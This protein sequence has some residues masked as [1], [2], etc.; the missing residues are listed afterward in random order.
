MQKHSN[1]MTPVPSGDTSSRNKDFHPFYW[2][3][4]PHI[5]AQDDLTACTTRKLT[6]EEM[7]DLNRSHSRSISLTEIRSYIYE[8]MDV[9]AIMERTGLQ[10]SEVI[11]AAKEARVYHALY[12]NTYQ[13]NHA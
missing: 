13:G 1:G 6:P 11:L 5:K 2:D 3:S 12:S 9:R 8:G 7:A 10:K 4:V